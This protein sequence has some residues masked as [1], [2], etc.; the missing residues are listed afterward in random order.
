MVN[1]DIGDRLGQRLRPSVQGR[2]A[3]TL[4]GNKPRINARRKSALSHSVGIVQL[5]KGYI[6]Q[7]TPQYL[8]KESL[9]EK[10]NVSS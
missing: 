6:F 4:N 3:S 9:Y 7:G 1:A 8:G 2:S 5:G 10:Q